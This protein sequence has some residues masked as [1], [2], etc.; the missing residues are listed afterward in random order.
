MKI[1]SDF[2]EIEK[3]WLNFVEN[4]VIGSNLRKPILDSWI[5]CHNKRLN[6]RTL[7]RTPSVS[8]ENF[9][10]R[11]K[12]NQT[13]LQTSTPFMVELQEFVNKSG[14]STTLTDP[15]G[16]ILEMICDESILDEAFNKNLVRGSIWNEDQ[17]G[18]NATGLAIDL[19]QPIQVIGAEHYYQ[20][21]HDLTCS[22]SP[23]FDENDILIGVLDMT[24]PKELTYP[25]T[26]GMVV[27][28]TKA[29]SRELCI[30]ASNRQIELTN[31]YL[32]TLID[33]IS[34]GVVAVDVNGKIIG[35]NS[36]GAKILKTTTFDSFG[37]NILDIMEGETILDGKGKPLPMESE[38]HIITKSNKI[39]CLVNRK[40]ILHENGQVA[41]AVATL[42]DLHHSKK[43]KH[44]R[45]GTRFT[46]ND[47]IGV[48]S[49]LMRSVH[50]AQIAA[51][52]NTTVLLQG[53]SGTGK[54]MF[55]QAIHNAHQSDKPFIAVNCAG[56]PESLIESVLFGYEEGAFTGASKHGK[57]GKFEL[58]KG[59]TIFLD[60][61]GE[62][63]LHVQTVLLRV[64]QERIIQRI[65]GSKDI[66]IDVRVI[67]ATNKNL[68]YE[69]Q[70]GRFRQDLYY[71]LNVLQIN[72][73]PLRNRKNDIQ[74]LANYILNEI[75]DEYQKQIVPL[76]PST[77]TLLENYDWPG[78]VRQFKNAI[79]RAVNFTE[80][81]R[82]DE[83][84]I[85]DFFTDPNHS[86]PAKE[87]KSNLSESSIDLRDL[88]LKTIKK[89]LELH[90][91]K[92]KAAEYLGI[93]R[94]TLYRKM[95]FY[96]LEENS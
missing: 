93:S 13:L 8:E 91:Q 35:I 80:N 38:K 32:S 71:R 2:D 6:P 79:E 82:I 78:N 27:A 31:H 47:I 49:E 60:E 25:H 69:A 12:K 28:V 57:I 23:I 86:S 53:E 96:H 74:V 19:K 68:A 1:H 72:I 10:K 16:V 66:P 14:F 29:I 83:F 3:D 11:L 64:L 52:G 59:G 63:P 87:I 17:A 46:F 94:S 67:A 20:C 50:L 36:N 33:S 61:I 95:K 85:T 73:P 65:G 18:T 45:K 7:N 42:K 55:A 70:N 26:L 56:T 92:T 81:N 4:G 76:H 37:K 34:D 43:E 40:L 24:G 5:R 41:G 90:P 22:A 62:M 39:N 15:E 51:K 84:F 30:A 75:N 9:K 54:E 88:E 48:S 89:A 21:Y 58:A 77:L 44:C